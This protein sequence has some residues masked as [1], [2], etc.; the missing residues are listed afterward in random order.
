MAAVAGKPFSTLI[1]EYVLRPAGMRRSARIHRGLPLRADLARALAPPYQVDDRGNLV[2]SPPL[3]PQG[4]GAAGG[5]ISTVLD[6]AK[7]DVALDA[8][9]LV[10]A[11]S[12]ELMMTPMRSAPE[13]HFPTGPAFSFRRIGAASSC[14]T[15]DGGRKLIRRS[16]SRCRRRS[17]R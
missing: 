8:G 7:F 5:V 15:P 3:S 16:I 10:S 2:P 4:D 6:L 17:S 14:G 1:Q 11:R 13:R 12:R 9:N